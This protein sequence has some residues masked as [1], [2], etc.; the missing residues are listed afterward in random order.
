[1]AFGQAHCLL[2]FKEFLRLHPL[3]SWEEGVHAS[4]ELLRG[5]LGVRSLQCK[6]LLAGVLVAASDWT[7]AVVDHCAVTRHW[8]LFITAPFVPPR[9]PCTELQY[10]NMSTGG[11]WASGSG[12]ITIPRLVNMRGSY[13]FQYMEGGVTPIATSDPVTF[14]DPTEITQVLRGAQA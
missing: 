12:S 4:R 13:V 5:L 6:M 9:S 11:D 10:V 2:F 14:K 8:L 7:L 1:M 3:L